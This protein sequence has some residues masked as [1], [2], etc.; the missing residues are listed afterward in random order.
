MTG[1]DGRTWVAG[2]DGCR[3][4]WCVVLVAIDAPEHADIRL[5]A[6]FRAVLDLPEAPA[7]IAVDMPIGLPERTGPGGR[8][9]ER[10]VRPLL[11][12]RQS[13]VFSVPPR[14]A[15][16]REDYREACA[17]ARALSDPPRKVAKQCFNL[18][19]K[20]REIDRE[21]TPA[22]EARVFECHRKWPSGR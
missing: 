12:P 11:G 1:P 21:M 17:T 16:L 6:D 14:D 15:V 3:A 22:L 20:I 5:C 18:F 13:S 7:I 9:P 10:H 8:A 2:V 4:G 19:P